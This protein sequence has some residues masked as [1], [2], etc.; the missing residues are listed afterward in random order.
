MHFFNG[1]TACRPDSPTGC[2]PRNR[3][4]RYVP[5][6]FGDAV[7]M[8]RQSAAAAAAAAPARG[9]PPS[10]RGAQGRGAAAAGSRRSPFPAPSADSMATESSGGALSEF[11]SDASDVSDSEDGEPGSPEGIARCAMS[12]GCHVPS[13]SNSPPLIDRH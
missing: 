4:G 6:A 5:G 3:Y 7:E 1:I 12:P 8:S 13:I 2:I 10:G 11:L 9:R